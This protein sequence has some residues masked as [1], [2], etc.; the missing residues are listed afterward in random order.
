[1]IILEL[2]IRVEKLENFFRLQSMQNLED[3][4]KKQKLINKKRSNF[5]FYVFILMILIVTYF[6]YY[7]PIEFKIVNDI[8]A[9][10]TKII[11]KE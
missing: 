10:L 5:K 2:N 4:S 3:N 11:N 1:M 6:V 9:D 8:I 7:N